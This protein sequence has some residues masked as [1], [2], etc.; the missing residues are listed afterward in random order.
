M[1]IITQK[2]TLTLSLEEKEALITAKKVLD[3]LTNYNAEVVEELFEDCGRGYDEV[4][5]AYNILTEL[6]EMAVTP[7][8]IEAKSLI[9]SI[10]TEIMC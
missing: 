10:T 5:T 9:L 4:Y 6:I 2:P 7:N 8:S 3:E 1:K